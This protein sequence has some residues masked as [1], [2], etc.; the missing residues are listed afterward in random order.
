[1]PQKNLRWKTANDLAASFG[2]RAGVSS[3]QITLL[4]AV[5]KKE[6]GYLS[7]QW[8]LVGLKQG[9]LYVK[10]RSAAAAQELHLRGASLVRT[11]NRYF[12]RPWIKS[13][14]ATHA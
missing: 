13:I 4:S 1:M 12:A 6:L 11:L 3:D 7:G 9:I 14:K 8:E 10:P 5:W 2:Y